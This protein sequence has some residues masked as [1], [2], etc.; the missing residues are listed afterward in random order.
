MNDLQT[1]CSS[2]GLEYVKDVLVPLIAVFLGAF[3]GHFSAKSLAK[4]SSVE[5]LKRDAEDR[6]DKRVRAARQAYVKLHMLANSSGSFRKHVNE[7]IERANLDGNASMR[8]FERLSTFPGIDRETAIEF[9]AEELEVFI[10]AKRPDDVD[11]LLLASRRY[12]AC[13]TNLSSFAKLKLEL[14]E[15]AIGLGQTERDASGVARTRMRVPTNVAN[16]IKVKGE[17]LEL[18]AKEMVDLINECADYIIEVAQ[19]FEGVASAY[20]DVGER[21]GFSPTDNSAALP[22]EEVA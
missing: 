2:S 10:H 3:G 8:T 6:R 7:M 12:E 11:A 5:L 17:N 20:F 18:F 15:Y 19:Q 21:L 9:N 13:L 22:T 16:I 4:A 14:H 1:A